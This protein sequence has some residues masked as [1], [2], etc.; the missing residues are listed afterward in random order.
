MREELILYALFSQDSG[1]LP[2]FSL[3]PATGQWYLLIFTHPYP[4][5]QGYRTK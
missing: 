1:R 3:V 5:M 4:R 2:P